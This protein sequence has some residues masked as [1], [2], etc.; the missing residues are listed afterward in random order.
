M[1]LNTVQTGVIYMNTSWYDPETQEITDEAFRALICFSWN[2]EEKE[3][4][5]AKRLGMDKALIHQWLADP[6]FVDEVKR[7]KVVRAL[8]N[9]VSEEDVAEK[10]GV[11]NSQIQQWLADPE[12]IEEVESLK[13]NTRECIR[14]RITVKSINKKDPHGEFELKCCVELG[15]YRTGKQRLALV[16]EYLTAIRKAMLKGAIPFEE[17]KRQASIP[18]QILME[19]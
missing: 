15:D 13:E 3:A 18:I 2:P 4:K 12:F 10:I 16:E 1:K 19:A 9:F 6:E 17:E 5:I 14:A 7:R 11:D 8:G